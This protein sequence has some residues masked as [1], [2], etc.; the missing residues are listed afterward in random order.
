MRNFL[1][2]KLNLDTFER[3][4]GEGKGERRVCMSLTRNNPSVTFKIIIGDYYILLQGTQLA[5]FP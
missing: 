5:S 4:G 1:D 2:Q 3:G